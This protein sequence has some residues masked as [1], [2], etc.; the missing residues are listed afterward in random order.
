MI[1][2][3]MVPH[4]AEGLRHGACVK[5]DVRQSFAAAVSEV[6]RQLGDIQ[7]N[8][9]VVFGAELFSFRNLSLPFTEKKKIEQVLPME[10]AEQIPVEV[11]SLLFAYVVTKT[12]PK[13]VELLV[14]TIERTFLSEHLALLRSAGFEPEFIGIS[15]FHLAQELISRGKG[16]CLLLD[17]DKNWMTLFLIC[18]GRVASIRSLAGKG[19]DENRAASDNRLALFVKQTLLGGCFGELQHAGTI[20]YFNG[21]SQH[22]PELP[23][24]FVR[25]YGDEVSLPQGV[26]PKDDS[27]C[28]PENLLRPLTCGLA[29]SKRSGGFDFFKDE[30]RREKTFSGYRRRMVIFAVVSLLFCF[31]GALYF[32]YDYKVL[33]AKQEGLRRQIAEVFSATVP[34]ATKIVQPVQ[35]LQ[36]FINEAK[37]TYKPDGMI[38]GGYSVVDLLSEL[39]VRIPPVASLKVV[40][41]VADGEVVLLK[42]V[43]GDFNTVDTVQRELAKSSFFREVVISSANQGPQ[44]HEVSFELKLVLVG[45]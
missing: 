24:F 31:F 36:V 17:M 10:L 30:F 25:R 9:R 43:T 38:S 11:D 22:I 44:G 32:A 23:G 40:R 27:H 19:D 13:G 15:G 33:K 26:L 42:A 16:N 7:G 3:V 39:S 41:L 35:Q 20:V 28:R 37:S 6:K 8:C 18:N 45:K 12:G 2:A 1:V 4:H 29:V 14:A 5:V 34:A 21:S